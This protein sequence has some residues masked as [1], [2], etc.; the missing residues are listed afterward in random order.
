LSGKGCLLSLL[1][2]VVI[3]VISMTIGRMLGFPFF[4]FVPFVFVPFLF[5]RKK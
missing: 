2:A 3:G 1:I 5:N 4:L